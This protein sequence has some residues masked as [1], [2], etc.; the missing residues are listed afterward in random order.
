MA[1]LKQP[2][3]FLLQHCNRDFNGHGL[4]PWRTEMFPFEV[5]RSVKVEDMISRPTVF[6]NESWVGKATAFWV[7]CQV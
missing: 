7:E 1:Q 5:E 3:A 2:S 4:V 6:I